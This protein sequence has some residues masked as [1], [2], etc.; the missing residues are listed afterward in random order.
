MGWPGSTPNT[1]ATGYVYAGMGWTT[2]NGSRRAELSDK[3]THEELR[4]T[5]NH[6]KAPAC[7]MANTE[8]H[9]R[10]ASKNA[11]SSVAK[12]VARGR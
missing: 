10:P 5:P 1:F 11:N 9:S 4:D 7:M 2:A 3:N 6:R 12:Q 8:N